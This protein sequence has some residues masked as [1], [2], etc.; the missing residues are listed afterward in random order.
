MNVPIDKLIVRPPK[1]D[2]DKDVLTPLKQAQDAKAKQQAIEQAR[3]DALVRAEQENQRQ[4][5]AQR[6]E[7]MSVQVPQVSGNCATWLAAAGISDVANAMWIISRESGCNPLAVNQ[8]SGAEG[9]AQA[10]P[11]SKTG[12][13][14]GDAVCQLKWMNG[15]V[16]QRYGSFAGAVTFWR[17]N[18]WY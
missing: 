9:I 16:E 15:Y 2:Y 18:G 1:P 3:Q 8:S 17:A 10:L 6:V 13:A 11:Y 7:R 4:L 12:C 14:R 5:E